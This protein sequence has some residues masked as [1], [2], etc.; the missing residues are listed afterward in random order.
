MFITSD[1]SVNYCFHES[2]L[3][4]LEKFH[5]YTPNRFQVGAVHKRRP[6]SGEGGDC[7]VTFCGQGGVFKRERPHFLVQ[8]TPDFSKFMVCPHGQ[9][10][11]GSKASVDILRTKGEG[12]IFCNFVWTFFMDGP[13]SKVLKFLTNLCW[14]GKWPSIA[15]RGSSSTIL[16]LEKLQLNTKHKI[17]IYQKTERTQ[18]QYSCKRS[19]LILRMVSVPL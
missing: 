3:Y 5:L 19:I 9:R 8:K 14:V 1:A 17:S 16:F 10:E 11:T 13:L 15:V 4:I 12:S 18:R 7:P 6:Q 2:S